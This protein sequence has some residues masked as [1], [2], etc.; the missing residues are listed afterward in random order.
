MNDP[1]RWLDEESG[2][3]AQ[4][5]RLLEVGRKPRPMTKQEFARSVEGI[6]RIEAMSAIPLRSAFGIPLTKW[7]LA[8]AVMLVGALAAAGTPA[9]ME[10]VAKKSTTPKSQTP[11]R[12]EARKAFSGSM[13]F[14]PM[15]PVRSPVMVDVEIASPSVSASTNHIVNDKPIVRPE[16][17]QSSKVAAVSPLPM[18]QAPAKEPLPTP[19]AAERTAAQQQFEEEVQFLDQARALRASNPSRALEL[20]NEHLKRFPRG[21]LGYDR[22][23]LT[24]EALRN[25]GRSGEARA[26]AMGLLERAKGKPNEEKLQRLVESIP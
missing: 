13:A 6:E 14:L 21:K 22:E 2:A 19:D 16:S 10:Y 7:G 5:V 8:L 1:R 4:V 12:I 25:A 20:L 24:I 3:S 11:E 15:P 18:E 23:L 17:S 9:L 26:R